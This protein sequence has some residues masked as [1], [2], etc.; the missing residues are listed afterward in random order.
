MDIL[1][2]CW[3]NLKTSV[4]ISSSCTSRKVHWK[5]SAFQ[6]FWP[7]LSTHTMRLVFATSV[8]FGSGQ[9]NR[10]ELK[11]RHIF[12]FKAQQGTN[13]T[14]VTNWLLIWVLVVF[15]CV[16]ATFW[17]CCCCCWHLRCTNTKTNVSLRGASHHLFY[18][19][20]NPKIGAGPQNGRFIIE[21]LIKL[22]IWG[23]SP[24]NSETSICLL[25]ELF[26]FATSLVNFFKI[27]VV[28]THHASRSHR[29]AIQNLAFFITNFP[30]GITWATKKNLVV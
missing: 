3:W 16:L 25:I 14:Y 21:N 26:L 12:F 8:S 17:C 9:P 11:E 13:M 6:G 20:G 18:M 5:R 28:A 1:L 10:G 7:I 27:L 30:N 4:K 2:F 19:G 24:L 15:P 22:M 23:E 29:S